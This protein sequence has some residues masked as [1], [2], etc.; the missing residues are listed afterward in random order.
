[1]EI[2]VN[3]F[4]FPYFLFFLFSIIFN[5]IHIMMILDSGLLFLVHP[6][7]LRF[8][9]NDV[10]H[11]LFAQFSAIFFFCREEECSY[12]DGFHALPLLVNADRG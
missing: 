9:L 1:M 3:I 12:A 8:W 2:Y 6:V 5:H 4:L 7:D 10:M 11:N